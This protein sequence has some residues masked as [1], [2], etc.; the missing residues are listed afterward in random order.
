MEEDTPPG[1]SDRM[2]DV[3]LLG[4]MVSAPLAAGRWPMS[5]RWHGCSKSGPYRVC[6]FSGRKGQRQR[7]VVA[8]TSEAYTTAS[9][10]AVAVYLLMTKAAIPTSDVACQPYVSC[11]LV[12]MR[13]AT[14]RE[15]EWQRTGRMPSLGKP[16]H[17]QHSGGDSPTEQ[18]AGE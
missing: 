11:Y 12:T 4:N 8:A 10:V 6:L 7:D 16:D 2:L 5:K 3:V 14:L 1:A 13:S 9:W 18:Y 15:L 17:E